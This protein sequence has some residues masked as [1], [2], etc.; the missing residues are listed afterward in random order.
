MQ[1]L[2]AR[3]TGEYPRNVEGEPAWDTEV[4]DDGN[5]LN[6]SSGVISLPDGDYELIMNAICTENLSNVA[7]RVYM[8]FGLS[9]I[10]GYFQTRYREERAAGVLL[11]DVNLA[12]FTTVNTGEED[13]V[14]LNTRFL[15]A[16]T[17]DVDWA[18]DIT[19]MKLN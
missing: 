15:Y 11:P 18:F 9:P 1:I 19:V 6:P 4:R 3:W 10:S 8:Y 14:Q 13:A 5:W 12:G 2:Q 7:N 17:A 16:N